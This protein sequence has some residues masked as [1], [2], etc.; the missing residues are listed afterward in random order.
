MKEEVGHHPS[1]TTDLYCLHMPFDTVVTR[2]DL[3]EVGI[4]SPWDV[5]EHLVETFKQ[6]IKQQK[7]AEE[8][9]AF[10]LKRSKEVNL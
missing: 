3:K 2:D 5:G 7:L 9:Q 1:L 6:K 10:I 4:R 8:L